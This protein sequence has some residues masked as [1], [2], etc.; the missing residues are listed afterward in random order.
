MVY[1]ALIIGSSPLMLLEAFYLTVSGKKVLIVEKRDN[2]GGA[3][4]LLDFFEHKSVESGCHI[5]YRDK[6]VYDFLKNDLGLNLE[7]FSPQPTIVINNKRYPYKFK[8]LI[9]LSTS[10]RTFKGVSRIIRSLK[11]IKDESSIVSKYYYPKQGSVELMKKLFMIVERM[12]IKIMK[13]SEVE[14]IDL[15]NG[16][17]SVT[18]NK[19]EKIDCKEVVAASHSELGEVHYKG[20]VKVIKN[21]LENSNYNIHMLIEGGLERTFSYIHVFGNDKLIRVGDL[22][23]QL[24]EGIGNS[25]VCLQINPSLFEENGESEET[26][27]IALEELKRQKII[28][29]NAKLLKYKFSNYT[30]QY[31]N[32]EETIEV[33]SKLGS[34]VRFLNTINLIYSIGR[35]MDR[36]KTLDEKNSVKLI[37]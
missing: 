24:N 3:W 2:L 28:S 1:D 22:S 16:Q 19:G 13:Q 17:V 6:K 9:N 36:W 25:L 23:F 29:E 31:R 37:C 33:K 27:L 7:P 10:I 4:S 35:E 12:D 11:S 26:V 15:K 30:C 20:K 32:F 8:T 18:I 21:N 34:Q 14:R 5:W